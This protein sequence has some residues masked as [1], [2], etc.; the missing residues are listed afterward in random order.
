MVGMHV[1]QLLLEHEAVEKVIS[2]TRRTAGTDHPKIEEIIHQD[3]MDLTSIS[4]RLKDID[5]CFHCLG[6][7][8]NSVSKEEF[9]RITCDY[10]EVLTNTLKR[11]NP[12]LT[13]VLFGAQGA[14]VTEKSSITFRRS[15]GMAENLLKKAG[16]PYMLI[17]RPGYI[18]PTGN[19]KPPGLAYKITLPV[20]GFLF[21]IFPSIGITDHDLARAMVSEG[22][23]PGSGTRIIE[24]SEIRDLT[25]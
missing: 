20:A 2:L 12:E 17:F 3:F 23:Q 14:D 5:V 24:N 22:L 7:Y 15:K 9:F 10:Q 18:H 13:F 16:F 8:Q 19:R 21:R 11:N 6:V 4:D 1:L 25:F